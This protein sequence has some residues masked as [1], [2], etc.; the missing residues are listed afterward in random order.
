MTDLRLSLNFECVDDSDEPY[1]N[2]ELDLACNGGSFDLTGE[3]I[4][5]KSVLHV[6]KRIPP[7]KARVQATSSSIL[8][9]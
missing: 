9:K 3:S 6:R 2:I 7:L 1:S 4:N 5:K 8:R